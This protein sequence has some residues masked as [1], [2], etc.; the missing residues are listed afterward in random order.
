MFGPG[1]ND[2]TPEQQQQ[3]RRDQSSSFQQQ[4]SAAQEVGGAA[5]TTAGEHHNNHRTVAEQRFDLHQQRQQQRQ[6]QDN[7]RRMQ[8]Q[9]TNRLNQLFEENDH[10][11]CSDGNAK[12]LL[13]EEL[14]SLRRLVNELEKDDWQ[15]KMQ[16]SSELL[17]MHHDSNYFADAPPG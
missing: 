1:W 12:A 5:T 15:Y 4:S 14:E 2:R 11:R 16:N 9:T 17:A 3:Q 6:I 7:E 8:I 13:A 10:K